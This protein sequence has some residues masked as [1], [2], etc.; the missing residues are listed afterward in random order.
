MNHSE[1]NVL[2]EKYQKYKNAYNS[3]IKEI[4]TVPKDS[5]RYYEIIS[6]ISAIKLE[7]QNIRQSL[8]D[9]RF[10]KFYLTNLL[11]RFVFKEEKVKGGR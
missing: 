2:K 1:R 5:I 4:K 11:E 10:G 3:L 9:E 7:L 6:E 8:L